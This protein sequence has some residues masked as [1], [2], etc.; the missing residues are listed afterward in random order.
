MSCIDMVL[1]S[2][3]Q[4][5]VCRGWTIVLSVAWVVVGFPWEILS[6]NSVECNQSWYWKPHLITRNVHL[7]LPFPHY[8]IS[9]GSPPWI[10]GSFPFFRFPYHLL[11][12]P[13]SQLSL[14]TFASSV[15]SPLHS[16]WSS[17]SCFPHLNLK[18]THKIYSVSSLLWIVGCLSFI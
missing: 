11:N 10:L 5:S 14:P 16:S 2:G 12:A 18:S 9:L 1:C 3:A 6:N 4:M 17:C 13:Q 15:L 8:E 7:G